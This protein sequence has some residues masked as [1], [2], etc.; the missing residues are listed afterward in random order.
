MSSDL[1][2]MDRVIWDET[3]DHVIELDLSSSCLVGTIDFNSSLFQLSHLQRF[4]L[5]YN[6][7]SNSYISP[8]F[9]KF[10]SLTHLDLSDSY[11][12]GQIS[13]EISYLLLNHWTYQET[14]LLDRYHN[15]L[16]LLHLFHS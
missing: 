16:F 15:N 3:T 1:L 9:F 10:S 5:S 12:K 2:L 8:K 6:K 7:F 13:F 14:N 11:F 4:D